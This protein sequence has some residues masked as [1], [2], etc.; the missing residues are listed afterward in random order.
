MKKLMNKVLA[1]GMSAMLSVCCIPTLALA[2]EGDE[3]GDNNGDY[4]DPE[5]PG[6]EDP[7]DDNQDGF[8]N[9]DN[10]S[11]VQWK[12]DGS[13]LTI[14]PSDN[15]GYGTL[16]NY[17]STWPWQYSESQ[18]YSVDIQGS[19]DI[20]GTTSAMFQNCSN[21]Q[22]LNLSSLNMSGVQNIQCM[23]QNCSSLSSLILPDQSVYLNDMTAAFDGCTSLTSL[24]IPSNWDTTQASS[25]S[26]VFSSSLNTIT[27]G[28]NFAF[29][30]LPAGTWYNQSTG[31]S[32]SSPSEI[33]GGA[34]TY[35]T[36][37]PDTPASKSVSLN[38]STKVLALDTDANKTFTLV[39]TVNPVAENE[40]VSF[41]ASEAG[42]VDIDGAAFTN[43]QGQ[44]QAT[45]TAQ[46][47]GSVTVTASWA[48]QT[49][50]CVFNVVDTMEDLTLAD[51]VTLSGDN[52]APGESAN[53][54]TLVVVGDEKES[55]T[56]TLAPANVSLKGVVFSSEDTTVASVESTSEEG[57]TTEFTADI[58]PVKK[59][60]VTITAKSED[61]NATATINVTVL[62]PPNSVSVNIPEEVRMGATYELE[63]TV[64]GALAGAV[65]EVSAYAWAA[66]PDDLAEVT[67]GT[68]NKA[69][70]EA[71]AMGEAELMVTATSAGIEVNGE[72]V[73]AASK[74]E[75]YGFTIGLPDAESITLN[76]TAISVPVGSEP[77]QL[78]ATV[79]PAEPVIPVSWE[80]SNEAVATVNDNGLVTIL[81]TGSTTITATAGTK[82]AQCVVTVTPPGESVIT[83]TSISFDEETVTLTGAE[84]KELAVTIEPSYATAKDLV[85]QSSNED[86][87]IVSDDGFVSSVG[88]GTATIT[89]QSKDGKVKAN[90]SITVKNPATEILAN[91]PALMQ[92][93]ASI[94]LEA[95]L[96]G[97]LPGAVDEPDSYSWNS[98]DDSIATVT[99]DE[100]DPSTATLKAVAIGNTEIIVSATTGQSPVTAS[101]PL[102]VAEAKVESI[103][104]DVNENT[105]AVGSLPFTLT[106]TVT[107]IMEPPIPVAWTTTDEKIASVDEDGVVTPIGVGNAV[108][109][110]TAGEL[111]ATCNVTVTPLTLNASPTSKYQGYLTVSDPDV[112]K[113]ISTLTLQIN[114]SA[115]AASEELKQI[116]VQAA[117]TG[118]YFIE[119]YDIDLVDAAG[120]V[121]DVGTFGAPVTV[122][123]SVGQAVLDLKDTVT[124]GMYY[125]ND[126]ATAAEPMKTYLSSDA[127]SFETTHFSTYALTATPKAANPNGDGGSQDKGSYADTLKGLA[128]SG[129]ALL[130]LASGPIAIAF[131]SVVLMFLI[132]ALHSACRKD[133]QM[134][135]QHRGYRNYRRYRR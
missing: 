17:G 107:P 82:E 118:S 106:A 9:F 100:D 41:V 129:D 2:D 120:T 79:E 63:A 28:N 44:A 119:A 95:S 98:L 115:R 88:K 11:T 34:G 121:I 20:T 108:I 92:L 77:I 1:L 132:A 113:L 54:Y 76:E 69:T 33:N 52:L 101:L 105:V 50:E 45:V 116:S 26:N 75:T 91:V 30:T 55:I 110:A 19:I 134:A 71:K 51:S 6:Y 103:E 114:D 4:N 125:I 53:E 124:F 7:G 66:M 133:R 67:P 39:A 36:I 57:A 93:G 49:A 59:G 32:W 13:T 90:C 123:I 64:S 131:L 96:V 87:A 29:E 60:T 89:A 81:A 86:V 22:S 38:Q 102:Q 65:D 48:G 104:L 78:T 97:D 128:S 117:G 5:D 74:T 61:G 14:R 16:Y 42:I 72:T 46:A 8:T 99:A 83:I 23:F 37:A 3:W 27:V 43:A 73:G 111:S 58:T 135:I 127:I 85:W 12:L 130:S 70:L 35:T 25:S 94:E 109:T 62:N 10:G 47:T 24:T 40:S 31:V 15:A 80:S 18:I 126:N 112:A 122:N 21:I 68:G 84:T 56:A